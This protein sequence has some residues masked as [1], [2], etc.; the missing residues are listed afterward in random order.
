MAGA[1]V[2]QLTDD[3]FEAEVLRSDV[4]VLVDFWA[5]WCGPCQRLAPLIEQLA[6]AYAGKVKV[7]KLDVDRNQHAAAQYGISSIPTVM[8][9]KDGNLVEKIIGLRARRDYEDILNRVVG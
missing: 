6:D 9:F 2:L 7:A 8:V 3:T 4:P 5:E 1:N